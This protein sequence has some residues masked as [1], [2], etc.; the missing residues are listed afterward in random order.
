M[1][2]NK[3]NTNLFLFLSRFF[4]FLDL[5][6]DWWNYN[7]LLI[8]GFKLLYELANKDHSTEFL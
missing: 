7:L 8:E 3:K 5:T 1:L 6:V 4:Y 2:D